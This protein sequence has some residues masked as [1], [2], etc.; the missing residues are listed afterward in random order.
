[1]AGPEAGRRGDE[2]GAVL[3]GGWEFVVRERGE[4]GDG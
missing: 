3:A 1:M 2:Q 4:G